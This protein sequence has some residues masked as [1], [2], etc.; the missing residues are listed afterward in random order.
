MT[1]RADAMA[2]APAPPGTRASRADLA[3]L[4]ALVALAVAVR[5]VRLASDPIWFDEGATLGIARMGWG[6]VFGAMAE[7]ESS[8][9]GFYAASKLWLGL[10][11]E[12]ILAARMLSVLF[13]AATVPVVWLFVRRYLGTR[14]AWLAALLVAL[15]A[16]HVRLSQDARCYAILSFVFA[17]ALLPAGALVRPT[18]SSPTAGRPA[19][20]AALALGALMG[21]MLWIHA[22]AVLIVAALNAF[23]LAGIAVAPHW[24]RALVLLALADTLAATIAAEPLLAMLRHS[25][26]AP[27]FVDRWID[28]PDLLE[29]A[30]TYQRAL[31]AP[32][33]SVAGGLVALAYAVLLAVAAAVWWRRRNPVLLGVAAML[34]AGGIALPL[35]SQFRPVLIDRTA[36]FLLLPLVILVSVGAMSLPR[37]A[38]LVVAALLVMPQAAGVALYHRIETR[39]ERW[40]LLAGELMRAMRPGDVVVLAES[41]F[42]EV[43]LSAE[44]RRQGGTAPPILLVPA[45]AR[46]EQLAASE[47]MPRR[48]RT[49]AALCDDIRQAG[50]VWLVLRDQ[51]DLVENDPGFSARA[52]V[53]AA[54]QAA[55]AHVAAEF[56]A[57]GVEAERWTGFRC[58][59]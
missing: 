47:L 26:A 1:A 27:A 43:A 14:E 10:W 39:K 24:R 34:L 9:P 16:T 29:T 49:A 5:L 42:L 44:I 31:V 25:F 8:P 36:L 48:I 3:W 38:A 37:R 40:D 7:A 30:R 4:L 21:A 18:A 35:A 33:L 55:G 56:K 51:P 13:G 53:R 45:A 57:A 59:P 20:S 32:H 41:A 28:T 50:D 58:P 12:S 46:L 15:A 11:G 17:L 54:F 22:T 52:A 6:T 23:V 19:W 2:G